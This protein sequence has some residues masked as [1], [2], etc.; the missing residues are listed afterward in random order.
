[1]PGIL[2]PNPQFFQIC[3]CAEAISIKP[4]LKHDMPILVNQSMYPIE[5]RCRTRLRK[6]CPN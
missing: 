2:E 5:G 1:M 4:I 6:G 3:E